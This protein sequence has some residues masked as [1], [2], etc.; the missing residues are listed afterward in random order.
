M[1]GGNMEAGRLLVALM[2][3]MVALSAVGCR[4]A[5]RVTHDISVEAGN[6]DV[7]MRITVF[8]VRTD[9]VPCR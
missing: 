7:G 1:G 6:Y 4:E 8:N 9:R 5:D 3:A 2:A